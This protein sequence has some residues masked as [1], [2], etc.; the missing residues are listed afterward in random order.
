MSSV[1]IKRQM[2]VELGDLGS[3]RSV[4]IRSTSTGRVIEARVRL[5]GEADDMTFSKIIDCGVLEVDQVGEMVMGMLD[6]RKIIQSQKT[7]VKLSR[8]K[9]LEKARFAFEGTR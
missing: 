3:V 6:Y 9:A 2:Q 7:V 1:D 8:A 5:K 4:R